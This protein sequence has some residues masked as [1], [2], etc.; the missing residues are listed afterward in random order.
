MVTGG[1]QAARTVTV[2]ADVDVHMERE[3]AGPCL[4]VHTKLTQNGYSETGRD[5]G[6]FATGLIPGP[7]SPRLTE[8]LWGTKRNCM[9]GHLGQDMGSKTQK[10]GARLPA[11]KLRLPVI[12]ARSASNGGRPS[13]PLCGPACPAGHTLT[14]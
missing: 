11:Q 6:P 10:A 9:H 7:T 13:K 14:H 2:G 12:P 4:A 3:E 1:Q 8:K 5:Q